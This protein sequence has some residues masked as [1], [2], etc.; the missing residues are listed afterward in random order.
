MAVYKVPQDV[1]A[2]DKLL[3]PLTIKQFV[4]AIIVF[5]SGWLTVVV[6]QKPLTLIFL[7][8]TLTPAL[9]FS[10][11]IFLGIKNSAQPAESYLAAIVRFYFK[12]RKRIWN[13]EGVI[14]R[15]QV[16]APKTEAKQYTDNLSQTEVTSRLKSLANIMDSRGWAAK[17][18]R[19]QPN[20]ILPTDPAGDRLLDISQLPAMTQKSD[21]AAQ[22]DIMDETLSPLAAQ[23]DSMIAETDSV[24]KQ[25]AVKNM[26]DPSY[27]PYPQMHQHVIDPA[28]KKGLKKTKSAAKSPKTENEKS[29]MKNEPQPSA[30]AP[31]PQIDPALSNL[32]DNASDLSVQTLATEAQRLKSLE[33]GEEISLH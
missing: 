22:Q 9:F 14:E 21:D 12:P 32:V 6:A 27:N 2:E 33:A 8:L 16:T 29:E 11:L 24:Y 7:P 25:R 17:D 3:G 19:F 30:P 13:Q 1:E 5:I 20:I 10:F 18:P 23:F 26:N 4:Y 31:A 28:G 15:V